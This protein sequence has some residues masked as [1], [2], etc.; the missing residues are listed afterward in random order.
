VPNK[1]AVEKAILLAAAMHA[2]LRDVSY[3]DRKNYFYPDLPK[4]YQI[5]Q[6]DM[7]IGKG[8]Y[9][10][11]PGKNGQTRRVTIEKLHL[12]EDAGKTIYK[13]NRRLLD[14]N[15][16]GVPL[17]EMVT[18]PD[19]RSADE[20]A[21]YL[22]RL[23]LLLRWIGVSHADME[24]GHLRCDANVSIRPAGADVLNPKTEI[25]NLNSIEHIREAIETEIKR[26]IKEVEAGGQISSWTLDWDEN[27][28][29]LSKMRS[30]ETEA[31]YRYF[32]EPDLLPL[33][34]NEDQKEAVLSQLPELPG[35][36]RKRFQEQYNLPG[37][38]SE[39]LTGE[40]MLS[41]YF[42]NTVKAY[43]GD[44]KTVSNWILNEVLGMLKTEQIPA[45]ELILSPAYLAEILVLIDEDTISAA[46]GKELLR[47]VNSSGKSPG[48]VV[49]EKGLAQMTDTGAI[50]DICRQ[51]VVDHPEQVGQYQGGKE[52]LIG[53]FIGQVMAKTQGKADPGT[54]R[55][56]LQKLLKEE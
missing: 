25:K 18:G 10:D 22:T 14:F 1:A 26:Q 5:S 35:A 23:R 50:E 20:A 28:Q 48:Q 39:L 44:P 49:E 29:T 36:R 47:M 2:D 56:I 31:D 7:A 52:N 54:V 55:G 19:L 38:D 13:P 16:C 37:Y 24:K 46:T 27:T 45:E 8:G 42:E 15:R 21:E 9:M 41:D 34:L 11:I 51:V 3:F 30:K 53:W 4:G 33:R 40:R 6:Y 32:R 43:K 17:I 12:E